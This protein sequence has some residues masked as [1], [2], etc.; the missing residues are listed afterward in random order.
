[1]SWDNKRGTQWGNGDGKFYYPPL[2]WN[3][4][5]D[6]LISGDLIE[7][8]RLEI[9]RD[10]LED[11]EYFT[12]L[13]EIS[14]SADAT[15]EQ[16]AIAEKLLEIPDS[17]VGYVDTEYALTPEAM[18]AQ[19]DEVGKFIDAYFCGEESS[20]L[21]AIPDSSSSS[22]KNTD[23]SSMMSPASFWAMVVMAAV[24]FIFYH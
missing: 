6:E 5:T 20:S 13:K 17:I 24:A 12:T 4:G 7:S 1:M 15:S 3:K 14:T 21:S 18:L 19:R 10:G 22:N 8:V 16:K 9:L 2:E 23:S 11:W